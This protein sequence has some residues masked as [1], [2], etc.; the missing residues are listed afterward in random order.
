MSL[1]ATAASAG[2]GFMGQMQQQQAASAQA[3]YQAQVARQNQQIMEANA[4]QAEWQKNDA[5]ERGKVAE[6]QQ[7]TKTSQMLGQQEARLAAQGTDLSGSPT[8]ILADTS[9]AGEFDA[10]T[11]RNNAVREAWGY[12]T[13]AWNARV[14]ANNYGTEAAFKSSF[15]PSYIGAGASLLAGASSLA[16]KWSRFQDVGALGGG[17]GDAYSNSTWASA[18][19]AVGKYGTVTV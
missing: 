7:R 9:R 11:V 14:G 8:D 5:I 1:V 16:D 2:L 4:K 6:Q 17:G 19:G 15:Q 12:D 13:K 18:A 10:L 3:N